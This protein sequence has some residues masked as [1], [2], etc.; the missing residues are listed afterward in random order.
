MIELQQF[1]PEDFCLACKGCCRFVQQNSVWLPRLLEEEKN[2]I[3][4]IDVV[5]NP[6]EENFICGFLNK[7]D[8]KCKIYHT[9][10]FE[11]QLYPFVLDRKGNNIFLAVDL[12]CAFVK[13][14]WKNQEFKEYAQR[15]IE[16]IKSPGCLNILKNNPQIIQEYT[17]VLDVAQA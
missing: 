17:G 5:A 7:E 16:L 15:L 4:R 2:K 10:P 8:N 9:R 11:C 12:N 6:R 3:G 1:I 14:G 13:E